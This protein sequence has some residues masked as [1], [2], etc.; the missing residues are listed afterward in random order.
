MPEVLRSAQLVVLPSYYREGIPKWLIE[1]A[2][3]RAIVT[4]DAPGCREVV[5]HGRNGLLVPP[6]DAGA[7]A[8]AIASLLG[9][10]ERLETMGKQGRAKAKAEF[11]EYVTRMKNKLLRAGR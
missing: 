2:A 8:E 11:K 6:R 5:E 10:R 3:G 9:D 1:A 7:S 4:T